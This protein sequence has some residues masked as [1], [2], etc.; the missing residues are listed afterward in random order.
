[1]NL[2]QIQIGIFLG[3]VLCGTPVMLVAR[4]PESSSGQDVERLVREGRVEALHARFHGGRTP[5]ELRLLALAQTNQAARVRDEPAR[6]EAFKDA[7]ARYLAWIAVVEQDHETGRLLRLVN[8]TAA[9]AAYAGMILSQWAATDLD[10]FEITAGRRGNT[11]RLLDLLLKTRGLYEQAAEVLRPLADELLETD[12][13]RAKEIEEQ[14][15]IAGIYD[16]IPRM[17]L[18]VCFNRA[19]T[20]LYIAIVDAKNVS[21]RATALRAAERDFLEL[22]DSDQSG[23]TAVRC[24]LG[25]AMTLREQSRYEESR[26]LFEAAL[27]D[28]DDGALAARIRYELARGEIKHGR[29]EEVRFVLRPLLEKDP[30][31]LAPADQPARFYIN[32]AHL[33]DAN[34]YLEEAL[35]LDRTAEKSSARQAVSARAGHVRETGLRKMNR[36]ASR[37]GSWP[38]LVQLFVSETIDPAADEK[39]QSMAALLFAARQFMENQ[40]YRR[41]LTRLRAAARRENVPPELAA[42]ILYELG[43]CHYRCEETRAAAEMFARVA[44]EHAGHVK[45]AKAVTYAY[46]LWARLAEQSKQRE[47]Y[48][49]LAEVLLNMVQSFPEHEQRSEAMWWLPVALQAGGHYREASEHFGNVPAGSPRH[50]EAQYRRVLCRRLFFESGR[51][52]LSPTELRSHGLAVAKEL[53]EYAERVYEL[54]DTDGDPTIIRAWSAAALVSAAE[55][56]VLD[57]VG[58]NQRALNLLAGFEERYE[59]RKQIGRVLA[60]RISAYRALHKYDKAARVVELFL[61]TVP[62]EEAGGT[63]AVIA[64]GM[65]EEVERLESEGEVDAARRV[66]TQSIPTFE[67]LEKWVLAEPGRAKY[68]DAVRYGLARMRYV[69]GQYGPARKLIAKLLEEDDR[70]GNYQ[71]LSALVLTAVAAEDAK[72]GQ[73]VQAREAWGVMLRDPLL[74]T[75]APERYWEARYH[76]L[77]LMLREGKAAEVEKAIRQDRVWYPDRDKTKWDEKL[78]ELYERATAE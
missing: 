24:R 77:E 78:N 21:R 25:L 73:L 16:T 43:V 30:D 47:D 26:R 2:R 50:E 31:A 56:Y 59:D 62:P 48:L 67:E 8:A 45:A 6:Q 46:Q 15:L 49:R 4:E 55:V 23:E 7:E 63:L 32:L 20:N 74:R 66:A 28:A 13:R 3:A 10:E 29:F 70:N 44:R 76:Y 36:L 22:V 72:P 5:E 41:A 14:Y 38:A 58:R 9:R 12:Q 35:L 11:K 52:S 39:T 27:R 71:R 1:M 61:R 65:Q 17:Q 53:K 37:G 64:R 54:A 34:S 57:G 51:A 42:E 40:E 68:L 69:A 75:A 18:D 33:W 19:W 60:A